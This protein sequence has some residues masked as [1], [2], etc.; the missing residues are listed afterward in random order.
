LKND[1]QEACPFDNILATF[2]LPVK[3]DLFFKERACLTPKF[4]ERPETFGHPSAASRLFS[5]L[6]GTGP[7]NGFQAFQPSMPI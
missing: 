1:K 2:P 3:G 5:Y 6:A 7:T 4:H